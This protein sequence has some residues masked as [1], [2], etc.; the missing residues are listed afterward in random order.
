MVRLNADGNTDT[1]FN[2]G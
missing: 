1:S 2:V